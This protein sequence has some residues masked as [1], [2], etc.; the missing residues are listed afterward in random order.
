MLKRTAVT[1][2]VAGAVLCNRVQAQQ[3][4][5]LKQ[6]VQ[7]ALANYGTIKAKEAYANASRASVQQ[8]IKEYLPDLSLSAQQDYGT[9]NGL[10]GP[11]YGYRGL[12]TAASGPSLTHQ[13]WN[14]AFGALYL[15]NINWDFFSFGKAKEKIKTAKSALVRD[16]NDLAQEQFQ[17]EI[18]VAGTYLNL[19]AAQRLIRSWQNNLERA[20]ALR[21]VVVNRALNGLIP[22]V[23][24]SQANAELSSARIA[25]TKAKDFEQEQANQLARLMGIPAQPF[26]LDTVFVTKVPATAYDTVPVQQH[27]LLQYYQSRIDLSEQQAKYFHTFIYPT[28]SVFGLIQGRGSGFDWN[29]GQLNQN[30]DHYT[31]NYWDG[32]QSMR[33]NYLLGLGMIWNLTTPLRVKQQVASQ[34]YISQALREEYTLVD[35]QLKAQ[36]ALSDAKMKNALDNYHEAPIQVKSASDAYQQ[37][38]VLY[39]NGLSNIVEVTQALYIVNRSETDR[40]IAYTNVWQALLLK[41]AASGNF[42]LFINEF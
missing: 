29:Y 37:K 1:L 12:S 25:L 27:P 16:Q 5:T 41:A 30:L 6:A 13:N 35:Q 2:Y 34:K 38:D 15:A 40:D 9:V 31:S 4:L 39:K 26:V 7:T 24:S 10:N 11:L 14:A 22:G 23:D 18:K 20:A 8:S 21:T 28:F 42:S 33:G 32:V 19:L 3:V 36:L 17:H